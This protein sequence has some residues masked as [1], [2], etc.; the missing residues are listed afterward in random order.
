M[1]LKRR[2]AIAIKLKVFS[3]KSDTALYAQLLEHD[4]LNL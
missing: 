1:F 4:E 2:H 3:L